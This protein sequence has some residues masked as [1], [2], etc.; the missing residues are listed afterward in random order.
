VTTVFY[1]TLGTVLRDNLTAAGISA[2]RADGISHTVT[3]SAGAVIHKLAAEPQTYHIAQAA[4]HALSQGMSRA[5]Y[6]AA[7]VLLVALAAT[8]LI[9]ARS[10]GARLRAAS[11]AVVRNH[12][13]VVDAYYYTTAG[14]V[15]LPI[16]YAAMS[17]I[18]VEDYLATHP[19]VTRRG[20][21]SV[22]TAT[23]PPDSLY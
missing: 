4:N 7:G 9:P 11:S 6:V 19:A 3:G 17:P 18:P 15:L 13:A 1:S 14:D 2:A 10:R 21:A 16:G 8:L 20:S 22:R 12:S 5:S 23:A